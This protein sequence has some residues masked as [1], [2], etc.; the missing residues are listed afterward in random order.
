MTNGSIQALTMPKWGLA[1]KEGKVGEWLTEEGFEITTGEE[2][3]EVETDK[4]TS[5]VETPHNGILCRKVASSGEVLPVGSLLAVIAESSVPQ[6]M[7]DHFIENFQQNFVAEETLEEDLGPQPQSVET[8]SGRIQ[9]LKQGE[10]EASV[11]LLHGFGGD[12]NNWL[13]NHPAL[14]ENHSVYAFDLLGHGG[15]SKEVGDGSIFT[16]TNSIL[17]AVSRIGIENSNWVGH[18]LG[19]AIAMNA[20]KISPETVKSLT[21]IASAGLGAE[22]NSS[23]LKGFSES[24]SRRELKPHVEL[25]FNDPSLVTRQLLEDLLKFKRIDGVQE[26]LLKIREGFIQDDLQVNQWRDVLENESLKTLAI[27][28]NNDQ[29]LPSD[30][31]NGLPAHVQVQILEGYGHMVQMEAAMEVNRLILQ[32]LE[33]C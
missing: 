23:Y 14:S 8:D 28:G 13:F 32:F 12:L 16:L 22:I 21:L 33:N 9:Y 26:S 17:Q 4:I 25:L 18:S 31:T 30:H 29:I 7:I 19:G 20:A 11:I 27:W 10:G 6:E 3:L 24:Q 15:S 5:A 1:M 2:V